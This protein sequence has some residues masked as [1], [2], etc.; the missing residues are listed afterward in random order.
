MNPAAFVSLILIVSLFL[1]AL[2][3]T[4][5]KRKAIKR[6]HE[7][8]RQ[9]YEYKQRVSNAEEIDQLKEYWLRLAEMHGLPDETKRTVLQCKKD[10]DDLF[11]MGMLRLLLLRATRQSTE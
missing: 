11:D 6:V 5:Q 3:K 4:Y 1:V 10:L 2:Q 9:L 7:L 8:E